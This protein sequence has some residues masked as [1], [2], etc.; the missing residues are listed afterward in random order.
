MHG[1]VLAAAW[2]GALGVAL[3][4]G[5]DDDPG[6][7][8]DVLRVD[9]DCTTSLDCA[10]ANLAGLACVDG[11]C[12]LP[13]LRD[14]DCRGSD[15]GDDA[16]GVSSGAAAICEGQICVSG[17]P[18][19]P[20]AADQ[21]VCAAGRCAYAYE[22][23]E[24]ADDVAPTLATLGWNQL[25]RELEN[26]QTFIAFTG[27]GDCAPGPSCGGP[28]ARGARFVVLGTQPT[29]EKGTPLT[30]TSCR[31][32]ACCLS[33]RLDP[34][35]QPPSIL[36]C[37][38]D[39]SVPARLACGPATRCDEPPP[40][41]AV[42]AV[43]ADLCEA[44]AQCDG[45]DPGRLGSLLSACEAQAARQT[46]SSCVAC[47]S[48]DAA[49]R[50][51]RDAQCG[52]PCADRYSSA[53]LACEADAGCDCGACRDCS[54]CEDARACREGG[55][56]SERCADLQARCDALGADGCY[57]VPVDYPRA[58]LT[59]GE[60]ALES[61]PVDLSGAT[62]RVV[63]ELSYVS[64]NVGDTYLPGEQGTS[65]CAWTE[66][67]QEVV[68]QLCGGGCAEASAWVDA[69]F[70]DGRRAAFPPESQRGNGLP[71][72]SQSAVDWRSGR[73]RVEVPPE[74]RGAGF[75]FRFLPR[76]SENA[77]VAIDEIIVRRVP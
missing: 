56:A 44:C 76:L 4:V 7:P 54:S 65:V 6:C 62:G 2:L 48:T 14:D 11:K 46:C 42:P 20:C 19:Q 67:P 43:C 50:A 40:S 68:V 71:F 9:Q 10:D 52:G 49:C 64:F 36:E 32:C 61:F 17:C 60:Q 73:L 66:A 39:A 58:E 13:C 21:P 53:C 26:P 41:E 69:A 12:R 77:A 27:T 3:A 8:D 74:L 57:A 35:L 25:G 31:A 72:G 29:P 59:P 30:A 34:P 75:R 22:S 18:D 15:F 33:C 63:I 5:C 47:E 1:R 23:F 37:P 24:Q 38:G 51:C 55:G 70:D 45:A 28:A 16:C